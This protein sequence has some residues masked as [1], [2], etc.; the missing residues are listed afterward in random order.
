MVKNIYTLLLS[1]LLLA[2]STER[3]NPDFR[4]ATNIDV[5]KDV[6]EMNSCLEFFIV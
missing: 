5:N 4:R 6:T 1:S 2:Q 3:G